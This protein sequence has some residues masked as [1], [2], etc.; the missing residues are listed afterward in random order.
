MASPLW[1]FHKSGNCHKGKDC[2]F[3]H[4]KPASPADAKPATPPPSPP[5]TPRKNK[6]NKKNKDKTVS[7]SVAV[8]PFA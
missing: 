5:N 2:T 8:D 3:L 1:R 4:V 7:Q 6:K